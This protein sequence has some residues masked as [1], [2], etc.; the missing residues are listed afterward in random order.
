[1][2]LSSKLLIRCEGDELYE[3]VTWGELL[4]KLYFEDF[5]NGELQKEDIPAAIS[6][7]AQLMNLATCYVGGGAAPLWEVKASSIEAG[8]NVFDPIKV[9]ILNTYVLVPWIR[10]LEMLANDKADLYLLAIGMEESILT[11]TKS[12]VIAPITLGRP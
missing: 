2:K 6:L 9:G 7:E 10:V 12:T 4:Q 5:T 1:M 8:L 3:E 11:K